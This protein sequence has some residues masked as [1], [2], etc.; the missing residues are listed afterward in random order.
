MP[1]ELDRAVGTEGCW[2]SWQEP[3][4][5]SE[6]CPGIKIFYFSLLL[7]IKP[8]LFYSFFFFPETGATLLGNPGR[9]GDIC[10]THCQGSLGPGARE[11]PAALEPSGRLQG[12]PAAG[13]LQA[14]CSSTP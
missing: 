11:M 7:M 8:N 13:V 6:T 5:L 10:Y 12:T 2:E 9:L 1:G 14:A 3:L 4:G